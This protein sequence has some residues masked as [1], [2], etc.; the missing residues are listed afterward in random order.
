MA[1]E[2]LLVV[3][4]MVMEDVSTLMGSGQYLRET[5]L[6]S[7]QAVDELTYSIKHHRAE[8]SALGMRVEAARM[9]E[10]ANPLRFRYHETGNRL[11]QAHNSGG[12]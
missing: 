3:S 6:I 1:N 9:H 4:T 8:T 5:Q 2:A 7:K 11:E 12:V 10:A